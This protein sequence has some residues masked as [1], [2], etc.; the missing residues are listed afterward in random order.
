MWHSSK[1]SNLLAVLAVAALAVTGC[2]ATAEAPS[3]TRTGLDSWA[4]D[5]PNKEQILDYLETV[6]DNSSPSY[7]PPR[8][9]IAVFD[10]DGTILAEGDV[11]A[12]I[13]E[14]AVALHRVD[15][16]ILAGDIAEGDPLYD[17]Y[18]TL[19]EQ[20]IDDPTLGDTGADT[21]YE[22]MGGA[23]AG[24][25]ADEYVAYVT[26]F[27]STEHPDLGV[28]WKEA[29]YRPM[30]ELMNLL[31]KNDFEVY[32]VSASERTAV[33]GASESVM[34]L[35]RK[36]IIGG[37]IDLLGSSQEPGSYEFA[38][39]DTLLRLDT[40]DNFNYDEQKVYK[41]YREIGKKPVLAFGNSGGDTAMINFTMSNDYDTLAFLVIHDD[42]EREYEYSVDKRDTAAEN[43]WGAISM[44]DEF[45][46]L[47]MQ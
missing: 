22:V 33:W 45:E 27:M 5:S 8:D 46:D 35:P 37:D 36:N 11:E 34:T 42:A 13:M 43:G 32:I 41:I 47:W 21:L 23:F 31:E 7:I 4:E 18:W 10:Q 24:M 3:E 12:T 1:P 30:I 14:V 29:F 44:K 19:Q 40:F 25:G 38:E 15:E 17:D 39:T 2:T 9:R 26:D 28:K 20:L 16:L 6:T